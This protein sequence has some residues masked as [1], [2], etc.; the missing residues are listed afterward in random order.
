M[1]RTEEHLDRGANTLPAC[2]Q[3]ERACTPG[4]ACGLMLL[5]T[6]VALGGLML[7]AGYMKLGMN[8]VPGLDTMGPLNSFILI[9]KFDLGMPSALQNLLAYVLP[10][11]EVLAGLLLIVG[12][13]ARGA[14][15]VVL[16]MMLAFIAG[17]VSLMSRGVN[18]PCTCFGPIAFLCP[19]GSPMGWCHVLRNTGFAAAAIVVM[20]WGPGLLGWER[21]AT[22]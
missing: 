21:R 10:W 17:I 12:L 18:E 6:R 13:W 19:A 22:K 20:A 14:A 4:G 9:G 15:L 11:S 3:G 8:I 5:L 2:A 7:F 1:N 16:V